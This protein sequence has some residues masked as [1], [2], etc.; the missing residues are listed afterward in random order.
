MAV[1]EVNVKL[2]IDAELHE[3]LK[4]L[5]AKS[6]GTVAAEMRKALRAYVRKAS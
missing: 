1:K 4:L 3:Q 6:E 2:R 5:A